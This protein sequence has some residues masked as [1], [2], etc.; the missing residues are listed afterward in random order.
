M[1]NYKVQG[2]IGMSPH[3]ATDVTM[4]IDTRAGPNIAS[5]RALRDGCDPLF[6]RKSQIIVSRK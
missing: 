6:S 3:N 4:I 2:L 1:A 5:K